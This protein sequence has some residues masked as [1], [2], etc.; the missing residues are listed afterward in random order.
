M[1]NTYYPVPYPL[2]LGPNY[3]KLDQQRSDLYNYLFLLPTSANTF[4]YIRSKPNIVTS[5]KLE[6]I[7]LK[8]G[9]VFL[10]L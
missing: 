5:M 8:T 7:G 6:K 10:R 9:H 1:T 3:S 4:Q 2:D